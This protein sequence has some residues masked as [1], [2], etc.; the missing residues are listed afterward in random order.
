MSNYCSTSALNQSSAL[1]SKMVGALEALDIEVEQV[2][3]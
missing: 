1:L 3:D 2:S